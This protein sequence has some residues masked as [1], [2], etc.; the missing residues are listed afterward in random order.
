MPESNSISTD[1]TTQIAV[2]QSYS[3]DTRP[4][5]RDYLA[6]S[7]GGSMIDII[8][9][10][11]A[12]KLVQKGVVDRIENDSESFRVNFGKTGTF[13]MI[14]QYVLGKGLLDKVSVSEHISVALISDVTLTSKDLTIVKRSHDV[15]GITF[16]VQLYSTAFVHLHLQ[17]LCGS[18]TLKLC[19]KLLILV[20][21]TTMTTWHY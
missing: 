21:M 2:L 6:I 13:A 15:W 14:N 7:D 12:V 4:D 1:S 19:C 20:H 10:Q 9:Y 3:L 16:M 18:S 8:P 5:S 11:M 17:E